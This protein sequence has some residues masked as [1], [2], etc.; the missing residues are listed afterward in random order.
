MLEL[1]E[2]TVAIEAWKRV[3]IPP[4]RIVRLG[5]DNFWQAADTG[6][7][8]PCSEIFFDRGAE[9]GCGRAR[10][11]ARLRMRPLHG[12]LQPRLHGVRPAAGPR[13][14]A[15]ADA[16]RRHRPRRRARR[17]RAPG[18]SARTSTPTAS[19]LIMDW[20]ERESRRRLRR[21][22]SAPRRRT[23]CSP[24]TAA[25]MS[26]LIADGVTP[27]NEGRGYICRRLI[28]RADPARPADRARPRLPARRRS[29]SSRWATPT[30]SC[31]S[32]PP[33]SSASCELEEERFRETLARGL[34]EFDEL[35]GQD[36][37]S[38]R[39]RSRSR[40]RTASRSS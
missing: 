13:A 36:A 26:F 6:P 1:D 40:R 14:R 5:K 9:H 31:A 21:Q 27:S 35:A 29:W 20:V 24:T 33:R 17:V 32:T 18:A 10:L 28:R 15:A 38:A 16:E 3:G 37:I 22:P 12:V 8:G 2:D 30:P 25:A 19:A 39:R 11:P 23:A 4:E 34:K 7:C